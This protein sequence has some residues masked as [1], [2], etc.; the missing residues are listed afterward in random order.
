MLNG[1]EKL[2]EE[3]KEELSLL[4]YPPRPWL[5]STKP[6]ILDVAI[7]G[8]GMAGISAAFAL[9]LQGISS[10]QIFDKSPPGLEGPWKTYARMLI[11]RSTKE[12]TGPALKIPKL[13]FRAW[14]E[15]IHGKENWTHLYKIPTTMW[16]DYLDWY[17][18]VL[19]IPVKNNT[20]LTDIA[21]TEKGIRLSF[22]NHDDVFSQKIVLATGRAGFGGGKI[23]EFM[24]KIPKDFYAHT[25]EKIPFNAFRDQD[26]V[27]LGCG[28]SGF[29]AAAEALEQ[30]AKSVTMLTRRQSVPVVNKFAGSVYPGFSHGYVNLPNIAKIQIMRHALEVGAPPP[31]ESLDRINKYD[32]FTALTN[33]EI[34]DL[35]IQEGKVHLKT[36]QRALLA[37]YIVLATGFDMDGKR[38]PEL[39]NIL[40]DICL[41]EDI[42]H[43]IPTALGK[44]PYL[45]KH[46]QFL[47]KKIDSAPYLKNIYCF[48]YGATLTHGLTSNDI[49]DISVGALRLAEGITSD[50]FTHD[51]QHYARRFQDYA[52]EEFKNSN[53]PFFHRA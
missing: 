34:T 21:A 44:Y 22:E 5:D 39:G 37:D 7:I 13:T 31:F 35:Q 53:Y 33:I 51:W 10:L 36:N 40:K 16:M 8:G 17:K 4:N 48:N 6:G 32:N 52:V 24:A 20:K 45:G 50:F 11:L 25:I 30:G 3:L 18:K 27:V 12:L 15:A 43:D 19:N 46:Y 23:P 26:V 42:H 38:Q 49:P 14:Y 28:A 29:D 1:L 41:W 2:E 47:E 9:M